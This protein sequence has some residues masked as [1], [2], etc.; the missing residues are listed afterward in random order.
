MEMKYEKENELQITL[1]KLQLRLE[2][3]PSLDSVN[4]CV[5]TVEETSAE[6]KVLRPGDCD[7]TSES[8]VSTTTSH[9]STAGS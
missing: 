2:T 6:A 7:V 4:S 3:T 5:Y 8:R 1:I 9:S